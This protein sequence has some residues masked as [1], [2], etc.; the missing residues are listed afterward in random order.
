M[1]WSKLKKR[2]EER[3]CDSLKG[4]VEIHSTR[5]RGTHD[6][7]GRSWIT[8]DKKDVFSACTMKWMVEFHSVDNQLKKINEG[9]DVENTES[10]L[11]FFPENQAHSILKKQGI[12]SQYEFYDAIE[13]SLNMPVDKALKSDNALIRAFAIIDKRVG[14]RR[15]PKLC[16]ELGED[17]L[18][19]T[20]YRLRCETEGIE[21]V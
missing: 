9:L 13:T 2:I 4:R 16:T 15:L 1:Q 17:A 6:D 14:K 21:R 12:Y 8:I 3:I 19:N 11:Y 18:V 7:E 20:L 10:N 5:Y